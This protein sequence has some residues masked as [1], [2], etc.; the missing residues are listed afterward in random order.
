MILKIHCPYALSSFTLLP[1]FQG[2][3]NFLGF[4]KEA[5]IMQ[6]IYLRSMQKERGYVYIYPKD[7]ANWKAFEPECLWQCAWGS[8]PGRIPVTF[9]LSNCTTQ[10]LLLKVC[11]SH[12]SWNVKFQLYFNFFSRL[13][14]ATQWNKWNFR[15]SEQS[16]N[17]NLPTYADISWA[18]R[19]MTDKMATSINQEPF[20]PGTCFISSCWKNQQYS[21]PCSF[22]LP[23]SSK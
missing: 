6:A 16:Q 19:I 5:G 20:N 13:P 22:R 9:F 7:I 17:H 3:F 21:L 1:L 10:I 4:W 14:D 18:L 23:Y 12:V 15:N 11:T 8:L 2:L